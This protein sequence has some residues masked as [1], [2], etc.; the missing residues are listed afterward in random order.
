MFVPGLIER[1]RD[2]GSLTAAEWR[3][4]LAEYAAGRIPDYQISALLMACFLRGLAR[5][6]TAGLLDGM[7]ASGGRLDLS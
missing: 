5:E 6:E 4:L 1:K 3:E 2:G 7:M